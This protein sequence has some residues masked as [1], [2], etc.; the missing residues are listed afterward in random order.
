MTR[1]TPSR[2]PGACIEVLENRVTP[3]AIVA[4]WNSAV[5][6]KWTDPNNWDIHTVPNNADGNQYTVNID[7]G[8]LNPTITID[9][10]ITVSALNSAE[11]IQVTAGTTTIL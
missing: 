4:T 6:G 1:L 2:R 9:A 3:S 7:E 11:A 8:V 5:S 10:D